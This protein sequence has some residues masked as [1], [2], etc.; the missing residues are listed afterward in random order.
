MIIQTTRFGELEIREEDIYTFPEGLLGF[1]HVKKFVVVENPSGG[2]FLWLQ[3]VEHPAIAFVITNPLLIKPDY[4]VAVKKEELAVIKL[5]RS[6]DGEV[7]VILTVP[8][9]PLKTTANLMGPLVF[10]VKERLGKQIVLSDV[11]YTTKYPV[12]VEK[13]QVEADDS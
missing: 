9:D 5:E 13:K 1:S 3:A 8:S 2:P 4:T 10:N 7:H 12:F 6:E 11:G